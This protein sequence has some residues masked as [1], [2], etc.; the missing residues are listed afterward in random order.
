IRPVIGEDRASAFER[1]IGRQTGW[2]SNGCGQR[3]SAAPRL[4]DSGLCIAKQN[5][6]PSPSFADAPALRF[7][8]GAGPSRPPAFVAMK[9]AKV[10]V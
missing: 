5:R 1:A 10:A 2:T 8:P 3:F 4:K 9:A 6:G 7:A